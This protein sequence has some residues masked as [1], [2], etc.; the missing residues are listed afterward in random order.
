MRCCFRYLR[1]VKTYSQGW[2]HNELQCA[3]K[4]KRA[5]HPPAPPPAAATSAATKSACCASLYWHFMLVVDLARVASVAASGPLAELLG[6]KRVPV[7]ARMVRPCLQPPALPSGAIC[8]ADQRRP[9]APQPQP[10]LAATAAAAAAATVLPLAAVVAPQAD[11]EGQQQAEMKR[12]IEGV[13]EGVWVLH[14]CVGV[15]SCSR[16]AWERMGGHAAACTAVC[17]LQA[18]VATPARESLARHARTPC[19]A[20]NWAKAAAS[21]SEWSVRADR[22]VLVHI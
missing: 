3:P 21:Y 1:F 5:C 2:I 9:P 17:C 6:L 20:E 18:A 8:D 7:G 13:D 16:R 15:L 14:M 4:G 12:R 11:S 22:H 19:A 10:Q